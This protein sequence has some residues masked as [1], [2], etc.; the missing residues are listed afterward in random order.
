MTILDTQQL[1]EAQSNFADN[2]LQGKSHIE[3]RGVHFSKFVLSLRFRYKNA[4]GLIFAS[5]GMIDNDK[6]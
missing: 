6:Y 5:N 3:V 1:K 2:L 4:S